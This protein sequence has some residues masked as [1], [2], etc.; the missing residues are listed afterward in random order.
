[1][2]AAYRKALTG[3]NLLGLD[4]FSMLFIKPL[5][6]DSTYELYIARH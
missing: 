4:A 3:C 2:T 6:E 1:M 5:T